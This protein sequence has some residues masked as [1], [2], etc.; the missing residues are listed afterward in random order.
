MKGKKAQ[1]KA[2]RPHRGMALLFR[3]LKTVPSA[4]PHKEFPCHLRS[5]SGYHPFSQTEG[6]VLGPSGTRKVGQDRTVPGCWEMEWPYF[7][8][9]LNKYLLKS[10]LVKVL[11]RF[12]DLKMNKSLLSKI[13]NPGGVKLRYI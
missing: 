2:L 11:K 3:R 5:L 1:A 7:L 10:H 6:L 9:L 13:Y 8:I 12:E 4:S